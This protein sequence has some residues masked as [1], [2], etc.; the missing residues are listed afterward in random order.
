MYVEWVV[1]YECWFG[2]YGDIVYVVFVC[3]ILHV[4]FSKDNSAF[5]T[6]CSTSYRPS[7]CLM[8]FF[9]CELLVIPWKEI[10]YF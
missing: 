9:G 3:V 7:P 5:N 6:G 8:Y 4:I 1:R 10:Q 2:Y